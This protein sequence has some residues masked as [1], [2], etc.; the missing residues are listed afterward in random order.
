MTILVLP[1]KYE[2]LEDITSLIW[3]LQQS[4]KPFSRAAAA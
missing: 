2:Y 3:I 1:E 4:H